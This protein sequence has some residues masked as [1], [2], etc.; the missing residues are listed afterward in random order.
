ML[1]EGMVSID[2]QKNIN[3]QRRLSGFL[4]TVGN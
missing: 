3:V 1:Q 2:M 4:L